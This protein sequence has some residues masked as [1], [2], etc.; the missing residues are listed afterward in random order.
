MAVHRNAS[1]V[2]LAG[3]IRRV[4][5][6]FAGL[7]LPGGALLVLLVL[8]CQQAIAQAPST[9]QASTRDEDVARIIDGIVGFTRWP[10]ASQNP[11]L[12]I[13]TPAEH[14]GALA[15]QMAAPPRLASVQYLAPEDVRIE[16]ECDV[17][18][19]EQTDD[20]DRASLFQRLTGLPV[21][22]IAGTDTGCLMGSL[23]CIS[24]TDAP[25]TFS[26]NL[27]AITRSGLRI[28]PKV[29]LLAHRRKAP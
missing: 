8:P 22:S 1:R 3:F 13:T 19:I 23:F 24:D 6:I 10:G 12:C 16:S 25:A 27:D 14:A 18:Y 15:R 2:T 20:A 29:L 21:L 5:A 26:A 9:S 17:V 11:R 28:N 4:R 7:T